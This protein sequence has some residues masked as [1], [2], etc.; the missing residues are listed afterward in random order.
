[1]GAGAAWEPVAG[2]PEAI[3]FGLVPLDDGDGGTRSVVLWVWLLN[4]GG[5]ALVQP[6]LRGEDAPLPWGLRTQV[7][8]VPHGTPADGLR[9]LNDLIMPMVVALEALMARGLSPAEIA[10]L[11]D[12][13]FSLADSA[14]EG[15]AG[16]RDI[17]G[18]G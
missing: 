8:E 2:P 5:A 4:D 13:A 12:E 11:R 7:V 16:L 14:G 15:I 18:S 9:G 17:L 3:T 10:T 6:I 1:M